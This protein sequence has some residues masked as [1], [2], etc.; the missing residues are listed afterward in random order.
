M[1]QSRF[2]QQLCE[3]PLAQIGRVDRAARAGC[4]EQPL[5][6]VAVAQ[7]PY[8]PQ[9]AFQVCFE[10]FDS[11]RRQG[12]GPAAL[13]RLGLPDDYLPAAARERVTNA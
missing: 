11:T 8:L 10:R 2:L 12:N 1:R 7:D 5:V 13:L 3:A 9:L 4:E 6:L